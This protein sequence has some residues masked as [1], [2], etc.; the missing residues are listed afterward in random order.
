MTELKARQGIAYSSGKESRS[1][2]LRRMREGSKLKLLEALRATTWTLLDEL[3]NGTTQKSQVNV[4]CDCGAE[5]SRRVADLSS[6]GSKHCIGCASRARGAITCALR[7]ARG[8]FYSKVELGVAIRG[9]QAKSRCENVTNRSYSNYGARGVE[10]RFVD[11][12]DFVTYVLSTIGPPPEGHTLD[13]IDNSGHY[14]AGNL[15]WAT[16]SEQG[17]NRRP[18]TWLK[19]KGRIAR[20]YHAHGG[21]SYEAIRGFIISGMSDEEILDRKKSNSG[22]P[23]GARTFK[24]RKLP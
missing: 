13:R 20:L 18:S 17:A 22:R 11:I 24:P 19:H 10:F 3:P 23:I 5:Y 16:R 9:R 6:G 1:H 7:R 21:Y 14:G 4:R 12:K 2:Y 15:R 8:D